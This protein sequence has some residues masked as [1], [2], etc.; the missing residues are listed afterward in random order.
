MKWVLKIE[1]EMSV[2]KRLKWEAHLSDIKDGMRRGKERSG[3][4]VA[5]KFSCQSI[6]Y[7]VY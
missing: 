1:Y 7:F 4:R 6:K 2:G 3:G 5:S